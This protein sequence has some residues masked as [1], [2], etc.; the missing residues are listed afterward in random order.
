MWHYIFQLLGIFFDFSNGGGGKSYVHNSTLNFI[1]FLPACAIPLHLFLVTSKQVSTYINIIKA[2]VYR[3]S[4]LLQVQWMDIM[5][6]QGLHSLHL[7][8]WINATDER[9]NRNTTPQYT[10][11][12]SCLGC[13]PLF[14]MASIHDAL[15][16]GT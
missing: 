3:F 6:A 13:Q 10:Q 12:N 11:K 2:S 7:V 4:K 16:I 9:Q 8:C 1:S 14:N 5:F 15:V